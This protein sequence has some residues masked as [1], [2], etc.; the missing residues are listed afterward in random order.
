MSS[1][2]G[3]GDGEYSPYRVY[4]NNVLTQRCGTPCSSAAL[5]S[6]F[7]L[8]LQRDGSLKGL[9]AEPLVGLP[10]VARRA[11]SD[12]SMAPTSSSSTGSG[13]LSPFPVVAMPGQEARHGP[14]VRWVSKVEL[15]AEMLDQ[16]KRFY[17][18][19]DWPLVGRE[20]IFG[21]KLK[22][23]S[24]PFYDPLQESSSGF[25][26]SA[27]SL[28]GESGRA[29]L[30]NAAVGVMQSRGRPY[31]NVEL[32]VLATERLARVTRE[33]DGGEGWA[34]AVQVRR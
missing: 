4:M 19:W 29:G 25:E 11:E 9:S 22:D 26:A 21:G 7:L 8:R 18:S 1:P 10:V 14:F 5:V 16:L 27:R 32:S 31:G 24:T 20:H 13:E 12:H 3:L 6:A 28:L 33:V 15:L 23:R 30:V 2:Q 17:W 34:H